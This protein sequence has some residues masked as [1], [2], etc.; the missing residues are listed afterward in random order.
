MSS[1]PNP[2]RPFE[3]SLPMALLEARE[4]AMRVFRPILAE[5]ELTEQQWRVLRA[6][7]SATTPLEV[8]SLTERTSL[9]A[10]SMSRILNNLASRGLLVRRIVEHDQRRSAIELTVSGAALVRRIA[11]RSEAAYNRIETQFGA[12][13]LRHLLDELHEL[14]GLD[15]GGL[16]SIEEA[17]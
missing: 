16:A 13:R 10:P 8:G 12:T 9:L 5:H 1:A 17:S 15:L 6:L 4:N 2:M 14:A 7:A 11:P 3:Q